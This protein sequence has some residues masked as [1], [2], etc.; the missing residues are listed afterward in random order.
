MIWISP[1]GDSEQTPPVL[2]HTTQNNIGTLEC[3]DCAAR[4]KDR[5]RSQWPVA[6]EQLQPKK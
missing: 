2:D 3:G 5:S 6:V 1:E 4:L